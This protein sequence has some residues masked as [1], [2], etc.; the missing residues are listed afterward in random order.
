AYPGRL[1]GQGT[2]DLALPHVRFGHAVETRRC[3]TVV[4]IAT[5][6]GVRA[7]HGPCL[8]L[9][10]T[11][12]PG[13]GGRGVQ[14]R[15]RRRSPRLM[16]WGGT[17]GG[18]GRAGGAGEVAPGWAGAAGCTSGGV[19]AGATPSARSFLRSVARARA[20]WLLTVPGEMLSSSAVCA[21]ERSS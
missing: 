2:A 3:L 18:T 13:G 9:P 16:G 5:A 10:R 4:V 7:G 11:A 19:S 14:P 20:V 21:S 8:R 15:H 1:I 12:R 17:G 6:A